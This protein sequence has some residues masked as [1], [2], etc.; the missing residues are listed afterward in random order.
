VLDD[1]PIILA[2]GGA[3][4]IAQWARQRRR[5]LEQLAADPP[6]EYAGADLAPRSTVRQEVFDRGDAPL[7][8]YAWP[9]PRRTGWERTP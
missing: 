8:A 1:G 4:A 7:P 5:E 3:A 2:R 6:P 9:P